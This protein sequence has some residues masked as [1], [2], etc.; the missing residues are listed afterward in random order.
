MFL[1]IAYN[2]LEISRERVAAKTILITWFYNSST[3]YAFPNKNPIPIGWSFN[4]FESFLTTGSIP[5]SKSSNSKI[6][7]LVSTFSILWISLFE[8]DKLFKPINKSS[9]C[10]RRFSSKYLFNGGILGEISRII[11][12]ITGRNWP[13]I[14]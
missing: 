5:W 3:A 12:H 6:F 13:L 9:N 1:D 14:G 7:S 10:R 8:N 2:F 11:F 4:S